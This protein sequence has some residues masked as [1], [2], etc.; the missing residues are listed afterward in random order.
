MILK[1]SKYLSLSKMHFVKHSK[2]VMNGKRC[3]RTN[4]Y[5]FI[6]SQRVYMLYAV[7]VCLPF[8]FQFYLFQF[9]FCFMLRPMPPSHWTFFLSF[10]VLLLYTRIQYKNQLLF[11]SIATEILIHFKNNLVIFKSNFYFLIVLFFF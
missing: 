5:L 4:I 11:H 8:V 7:H 10:Y 3:F 1:T 6:V 9:S 2:K